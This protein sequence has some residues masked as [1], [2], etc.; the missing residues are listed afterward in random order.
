M[1]VDFVSFAGLVDSLGGI[2]IEFEN[3]AFD[4]NSGLDVQQS[5][6]VT[7]GGAQAL[8]YVRSRHLVEVIGGQERPDPTGDIGRVERQQRF[9]SAVFGKLG[10]S[11]NPITLA[12]AANSASGGLRIDDGMSLVDA[13]RLAWRLRSLDAESVVLPTYQGRNSAGAVLFLAEPDAGA[14]LSTFR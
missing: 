12:R 8:A 9:L 6:P 7:L 14:V 3:P 1:E 2:T 10:D 13:M 4:R 5:G 11:K